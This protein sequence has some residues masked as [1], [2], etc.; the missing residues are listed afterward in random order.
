M[1]TRGGGVFARGTL[2]QGAS[3][4]KTP[5]LPKGCCKVS[6][7]WV[8]SKGLDG[9]GC[10][11]SG[12]SAGLSMLFLFTLTFS[13][14]LRL[15]LTL[16]SH[17]QTLIHLEFG[18]SRQRQPYSYNLA[19]IPL[20]NE[21]GTVLSVMQTPQ[22]GG[23]CSQCHPGCVLEPHGDLQQGTCTWKEKTQWRTSVC[24][25]SPS[26]VLWLPVQ[27]VLLP[28]ACFSLHHIL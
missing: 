4:P 1:G 7:C 27:H 16:Q 22:T 25:C 18:F 14:F 9:L 17:W 3:A 23:S 19:T 26:A 10:F 5:A 24:S 21:R 28:A 13:S 6:P 12:F 20:Q 2:E 11:F 8:I 15:K